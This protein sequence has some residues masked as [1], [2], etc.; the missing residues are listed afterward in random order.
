MDSFLPFP[1]LPCTR[2]KNP[3]TCQRGLYNNETKTV[4]KLFSEFRFDDVIYMDRYMAANREKRAELEA[5][6]S[7]LRRRIDATTTEL[8]RYHQVCLTDTGLPVTVCLDTCLEATTRLLQD[9]QFSA[10]HKDAFA[11]SVAKLTALAAAL[12]NE[13]ESECVCVCVCVFV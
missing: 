12:A 8:Q 13:R 4:H 11:K 7:D 1:R 5:C 10:L 3:P 9:K 6:I 2:T